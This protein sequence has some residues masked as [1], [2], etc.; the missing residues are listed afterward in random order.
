[1]SACG[2][3]AQ[4]LAPEP[5]LL[6]PGVLWMLMKSGLSPAWPRLSREA[7]SMPLASVFADVPESQIFS[8]ALERK[9]DCGPSTMIA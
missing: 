2:T 5:T 1:M 4:G 3:K 8:A 9:Y 7:H 6:E